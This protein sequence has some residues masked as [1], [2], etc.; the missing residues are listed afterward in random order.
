VNI[1]FSVL[2][3][4]STAATAYFWWLPGSYAWFVLSISD[5]E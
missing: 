3:V 5:C 2:I 4:L 1:T